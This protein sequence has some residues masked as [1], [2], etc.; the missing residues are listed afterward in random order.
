MAVVRF[1]SRWV[2]NYIQ[3][4]IFAATRFVSVAVFFSLVWPFGLA[5]AAEPLSFS[6]Q[7]PYY[8]GQSRAA[9]VPGER[10]QALFAI[11]NHGPLSWAGEAV[12]ELPPGWLPV[13]YEYWRASAREQRYTLTKSL[14][15]EAGFDQWFDLLSV[16]VPREA[17]PGSYPVTVTANNQKKTV[18]VQV[19]AGAAAAGPVSVTNILFPLDRDGKLEERLERNTLVLRDR[20]WDYYKNI[21]AGKGASN[22]EV[23]AVHP[24]AHMGVD[25]S[26]PAGEQKLVVITVDLLSLTDRQP[27][28]GLFTPGTTGEDLNAGSMGGHHDALVALVALTGEPVQHFLLPVYSDERLMNSGRFRLRVSLDD[29]I[30]APAIKELPLTIIKQNTKAALVVGVAAALL[31]IAMLLSLLRIKK[32]LA[33]MRTRWLVTIALFGAAAFAAVSV[34]STLFGD[35]FHVLL[36]PFGFLISGL[37]SGVCLYMIIVALVVLI[38]SPG[39]VALMA[40]VRLLLGILAFGQLTPILLLSYGIHAFLL[41]ALLAGGG[42]Y[43]WLQAG[44]GAAQDYP[45]RRIALVAA[46]C[47]VADSV[48]T[49]VSLQAMAVL[50]RLYYADWYIYLLL[51]VS[52]FL[53]TAIGAVCGMALGR[54]LATVGGD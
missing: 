11:D 18:T 44:R 42:V 31:T 54:R 4:K 36:G 28:P 40:L 27:L 25:V 39:V 29:G 3:K 45:L 22:P 52:G 48:A 8:L 47:G 43:A 24:V 15:L 21:L 7:M 5:F 50:Y 53:Y 38:P 49:Y 10:V 16:Q 34:P 2:G 12:I 30:A 13:G 41:E 9:A 20:R 26:N 37:F 32:I 19:A 46:I 17:T 33:S 35:F 23:E 6:L 51:A 1:Y 14:A